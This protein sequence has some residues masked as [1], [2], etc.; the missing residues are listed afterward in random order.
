MLE[1]DK[2]EQEREQSYDVWF[3]RWWA[4]ADLEQQ[5]KIANCQGY[6]KVIIDFNRYS[7]YDINR[8]KH[9]RFTQKLDDKLPG[10]DIGYIG[11]VW[12]VKEQVYKYG[13]PINW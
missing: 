3:E 4:K 7:L 5:I 12:D 9:S 1:L 8:L 11:T 6:T 10:F 13:I 2:L